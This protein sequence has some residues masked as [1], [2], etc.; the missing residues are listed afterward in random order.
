MKPLELIQNLDTN[1]IERLFSAKFYQKVVPF[2]HRISASG[3]GWLY[4]LV[5]L[6]VATILG[7]DH[8]YFMTLVQAFAIERSFYYVLKNV[9]KRN[10]PFRMMGIT[11]QVNPSD[12]FSFPSGHTSAAFLFAV[13]TMH[14]LPML[15]IPL[16]IWATLVGTSRVVLGVHYPTDILAGAFMGSTIAL[17]NIPANLPL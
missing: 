2:S 12:Q 5:A 10:R 15:M 17:L 7:F 14:L 1:L 4:L 3:D 8:W 13:I 6:F 9:L 16:L 11:N